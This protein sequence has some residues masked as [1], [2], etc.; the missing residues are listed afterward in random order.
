MKSGVIDG[1]ILTADYN[2]DKGFDLAS[3]EMQII[4]ALRYVRNF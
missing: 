3:R 4:G 1:K 2:L